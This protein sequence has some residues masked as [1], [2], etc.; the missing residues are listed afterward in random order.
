MPMYP[1]SPSGFTDAL[2]GG[3]RLATDRL[4]AASMI[5][6]RCKRKKVIGFLQ[7]EAGLSAVDEAAINI[8]ARPDACLKC[9]MVFTPQK[10]GCIDCRRAFSSKMMLSCPTRRTSAE[11]KGIRCSRC[12]RSGCCTTTCAVASVAESLHAYKLSK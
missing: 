3:I 6:C 7:D 5:T 2:V 11:V 9:W 1:K 10:N 4:S 12:S 8:E